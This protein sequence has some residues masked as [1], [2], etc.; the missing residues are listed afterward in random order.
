MRRRIRGIRG[1]AVNDMA[2]VHTVDDKPSLGRRLGNALEEAR[3]HYC[4]FGAHG[5]FLVCKSRVLHRQIEI[6]SSVP[7]LRHH[8]YMR[9]RTSDLPL[10]QGIFVESQYDFEL[11]VSP[12]VI[13][14]VGANIGLASVFYANKYPSA[15]VLAIEPEASNFRMLAKNTAPYSNVT[16]IRAALWKE[17][18][19]VA[20]SNPNDDP[21]SFWG[22]RTADLGRSPEPGQCQSVRAATLDELLKEN[23]VDVVDLLKLDIE[24]AEKE[25]FESSATWIGRVGAIAI[26]VHD[27]FKE[28]CSNSVCAATTDFEVRSQRGETTFLLRKEF[29]AG[30]LQRTDL[31][32]NISSP[33]QIGLHLPLRVRATS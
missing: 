4:I 3:L 8:V 27:R 20:I 14:D 6:R 30:A 16:A 12:K 28:G 22:F 17:S 26:E 33:N 9:L 18:C 31:M 24:G 32:A 25:V 29:P 11:P 23:G 13:V 2:A 1:R 5:C 19:E 15:R 7:G 21:W 10:F